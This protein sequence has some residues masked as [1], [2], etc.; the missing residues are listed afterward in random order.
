MKSAENFKYTGTV[1]NLYKNTQKIHLGSY[2]KIH[3]VE[4]SNP[5]RRFEIRNFKSE[6]WVSMFYIY[7]VKNFCFVHFKT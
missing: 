6:K 7:L 4:S 2:Y 5:L 1:K 3:D